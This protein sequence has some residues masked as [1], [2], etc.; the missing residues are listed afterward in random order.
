MPGCS[1]QVKAN[2]LLPDCNWIKGKGCR[3]AS[4]VT[5]AEAALA[6][7]LLSGVPA[8]LGGVSAAP[9]AS[10]KDAQIRQLLAVIAQKDAMIQQLQA[11]L[12]VT[13]ASA[14]AA[15]PV[16]KT[17]PPKTGKIQ[18]PLQFLTQANEQ[19]TLLETARAEQVTLENALN[20]SLMDQFSVHYAQYMEFLSANPD[21]EKK[22]VQ[23]IREKAHAAFAALGSSPSDDALFTFFT[24]AAE[25]MNVVYATNKFEFASPRQF[26]WADPIVLFSWYAMI[27]KMKPLFMALKQVPQSS[28]SAS[29]LNVNFHKFMNKFTEAFLTN[30]LA[31]F[32]DAEKRKLAFRF[33]TIMDED[34]MQGVVKKFKLMPPYDQFMKLVAK[35]T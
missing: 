16:G 4:P 10:D 23:Q 8:A 12:A 33:S 25:W 26:A 3:V 15:A 7:Q 6:L 34:E 32:V 24:S 21:T 18:Y 11:Q 17:K 9:A 27:L 13:S 30:E 5:L 35:L 19:A 31:E 29:V 14:A 28:H 1:R 20:Y 22:K 2:C